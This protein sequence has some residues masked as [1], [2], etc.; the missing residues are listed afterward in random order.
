[1]GA[2]EFLLTGILSK[3]VFKEVYVLNYPGIIKASDNSHF[4]SP[5]KWIYF[6]NIILTHCS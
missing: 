5:P 6:F 1:M 4:I 2:L 3:M